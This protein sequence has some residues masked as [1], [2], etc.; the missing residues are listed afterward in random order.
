MLIFASCS[1]TTSPEISKNLDLI[2]PEHEID[3][4]KFDL[5]TIDFNG[6]GVPDE[7]YSSKFLEGDDLYIFHNSTKGK[8]LTLKTTNFSEDG[9]YKVD[10]IKAFTDKLKGDL[11]IYTHFNGA[12][13]ANLNYILKYKADLNWSLAY[14]QFQE[15]NCPEPEACFTKNC[16]IY[17]N[18]TLNDSTDWTK[19][20]TI[21]KADKEE[22]TITKIIQ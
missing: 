2:I 9:L 1:G 3:T 17:Q 8:V 11:I 20:K 14:S 16:E 12:G 18:I 13:G 5:F 21:D 7:V 15:L 22:C 6:D 10:S 4:S 19:F